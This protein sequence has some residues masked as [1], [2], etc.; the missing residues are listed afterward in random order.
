MLLRIV[1]WYPDFDPVTLCQ[2]EVPQ[3]EYENPDIDTLDRIES[4]YK[5]FDSADPM[6][7]SDSEFPAFLLKKY[8]TWKLVPDPF[9]EVVVG[10]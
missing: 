4:A 2:V 8:P 10:N 1:R 3:S 6:P 5:E 7:D 9:L